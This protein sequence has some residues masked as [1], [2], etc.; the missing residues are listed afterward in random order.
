VLERR[1]AA[2]QSERGQPAPAGRL[3]LPPAGSSESV[4]GSLVQTMPAAWSVV[5]VVA[6]LHG[7]AASIVSLLLAI[8]AASPRQAV[9]VANHT[10]HAG[11]AVPLVHENLYSPNG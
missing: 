8:H 2:A 5:A 7:H 6:A 4:G 9:T 3:P 1:C 10:A 11:S